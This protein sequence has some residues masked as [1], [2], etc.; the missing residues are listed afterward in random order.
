[1]GSWGGQVV[2]SFEL[3]RDDG[4][5]IV[6]PEGPLQTSDFAAIANEVDPFIEERGG[7]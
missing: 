4:I 7:L 3:L 1:M 2:I 5:L 6:S